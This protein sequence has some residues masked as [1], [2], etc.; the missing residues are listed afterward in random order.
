MT[1]APVRKVKLKHFVQQSPTP[2]SLCHDF[3]CTYTRIRACSLLSVPCPLVMMT[4]CARLP[5]RG[6]PRNG[7]HH[8]YRMIHFLLSK[9]MIIKTGRAS[10]WI[11][12]RGGPFLLSLRERALFRHEMLRNA[13]RVLR[14]AFFPTHLAAGSCCN[15]INVLRTLAHM[16]N[17]A[18]LIRRLS[19]RVSKYCSAS[20]FTNAAVKY[21]C[22]NFLEAS[23]PAY[24]SEPTFRPRNL[25]E[26]QNITSYNHT[27]TS[28]ELQKR[29]IEST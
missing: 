3:S 4:V 11:S 26:P 17:N 1:R 7:C 6:S 27:C 18:N 16:T 23:P 24:C 2:C 8:R 22:T 20:G 5:D 12:S 15:I 10:I 28:I 29:Q 13:Y 25:S 19:R 14:T 21:C 9:L